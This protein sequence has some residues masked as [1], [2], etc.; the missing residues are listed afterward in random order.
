MQLIL[1]LA[2][3]QSTKVL[4]LLRVGQRNVNNFALP[5]HRGK[6]APTS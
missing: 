6:S 2:D 1:R 5:A 3:N 4:L